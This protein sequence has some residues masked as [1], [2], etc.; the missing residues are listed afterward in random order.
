MVSR[1]GQPGGSGDAAATLEDVFAALPAP[2]VERILYAVFVAGERRM[3][4]RA[5]LC[6]VCKCAPN[7]A[8]LPRLAV[9]SGQSP[10]G[11]AALALCCGRKPASHTLYAKQVTTCR[12]RCWDGMPLCRVLDLFTS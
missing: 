11:T 6:C 1:E 10:G 7:S 8:V 2:L 9:R 5:R 4:A 3:A 12:S